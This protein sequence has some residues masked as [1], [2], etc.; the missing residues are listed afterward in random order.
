M[1]TG[2]Q[3]WIIAFTIA[4]LLHLLPVLWLLLPAKQP[5][6]QATQAASIV[7][8]LAPVATAP[9]VPPTEL[10]PG[11]QLQDLSEAS[12]QTEAQPEPE[13]VTE[14]EE[15]P[16][17]PEVPVADPEVSLPQPK[18]QAKE[19]PTEVPQEEVVEEPPTEQAQAA[20]AQVMPSAPL[21]AETV[22]EQTAAAEDAM[23]V[24]P[25]SQQAVVNWRDRLLGQLNRAKRYPPHAR[26]RRQEG[27]SYLRF[28]MDRQ[29]NVLQASLEQSSGHSILDQE[30]LAM[31][32]RAEPLI[33]PPEDVTGEVIELVVPVAFF[34][35][36]AR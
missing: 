26:S 33:V 32:K 15:I 6:V 11:P 24:N 29:G 22:A 17:L 30:T 21:P 3:R 8:E 1:N 2:S 31:I 9:E 23:S 20:S 4:V 34:L 36:D 10:P 16:P 7:V 35:K 18:E 19:T 12:E 13:P 5:A 28:S 27:V 14:V 25:A